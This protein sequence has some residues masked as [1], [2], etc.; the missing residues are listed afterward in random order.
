[1][2]EDHQQSQRN[3]GEMLNNGD[4][5]RVTHN[6]F[7]DDATPQERAACRAAAKAEAKVLV[8]GEDYTEQAT[9][10]DDLVFCKKYYKVHAKMWEGFNSD[11]ASDDFKAKR[12]EQGSGEDSVGGTH[13]VRVPA[14]SKKKKRKS[15]ANARRTLFSKPLASRLRTSRAAWPD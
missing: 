15:R 14:P 6:A 8:K 9:L 7:T 3:V 12:E 4:A 10:D 5:W 11:D 1:M 2:K 13:H